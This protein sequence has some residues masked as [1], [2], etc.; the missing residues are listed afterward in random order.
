MTGR[1]RHLLVDSLGLLL[2]VLVTAASVPD[3][4]AACDVLALLP[5]DQF[6]RLRVVW[7][8]AA[9]ATGALAAEV[10]FWAQYELGIVRREPN[11]GWVLLPKRWVVERTFAWLARCRRH[12][13]DYE[14]LPESSEA[15]V[16]ISMIQLMLRRLSGEKHAAPFRYPRPQKKTAA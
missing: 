2:V 4:R 8:D 3:A 11:S 14:R 12:G 6:P 13:R 15:Q 9:Y 7:A 16:Q 5:L 1:K 10:A